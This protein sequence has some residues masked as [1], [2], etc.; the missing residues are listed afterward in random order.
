MTRRSAAFESRLV[1]NS[2]H[3]PALSRCCRPEP[4]ICTSRTPPKSSGSTPRQGAALQARSSRRPATSALPR[5][6]AALRRRMLHARCTW[7]V[8]PWRNLQMRW[9]L[10]IRHVST[11]QRFGD[12]GPIRTRPA[13]VEDAPISRRQCLRVRDAGRL[14]PACGHSARRNRRRPP[15]NIQL[16]S[17]ASPLRPASAGIIRIQTE[18]ISAGAPC[19]QPE[20]LCP[21]ALRAARKRA[22]EQGRAL[23][24][25]LRLAGQHIAGTLGEPLRIFQHAQFAPPHRSAHWNR[26]RCRSVR[27]AAR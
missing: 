26:C 1:R 27:P 6:S 15:A 16:S 7:H 8:S 24:N 14:R 9:C 11:K 18:T 17:S 13:N 12:N 3:A 20:G 19:A 5:A 25:C 23:W 21:S 2:S 4:S 22:V 10:L